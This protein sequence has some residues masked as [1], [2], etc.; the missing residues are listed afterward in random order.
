MTT[1]AP[2]EP[3]ASTPPPLGPRGTLRWM[4]RQLTSMRTALLLL[5]AL[6]IAAVPGSLIPQ[7]PVDPLA[8]G[9]FKQR[10]PT[11]SEWY[12]RF[13]MFEVFSSPWF[14]AIYLL[15][16]ISLVGCL[17]PR[18]RVYLQGMRAK[19]PAAPR[20]LARLPE[21]ARFVVDAPPA[22]VLDAAHAS[23]R[24]RRFRLRRAE[25]SVCA[26]R[27]YLR[28]TGNLL[29]HLSLIA[30]LIGVGYGHLYGFRGT[31]LVVEG[32]GFANTVT[33]YDNLRTGARFD[34]DALP[35]YS[36]TLADFNARYETEGPARGAP[37]DF[38]ATV[39]YVSKPGEKPVRKQIRV[40]HPLGVADA[41]L[42][43]G[44]H[45]YAPVV[46]V[47]DGTGAV[48]FAGA[49]P[50]LPIDPAGLS[51]RGVVKVPDAKPTQLGFQGFFLPSAAFDA[52]RG[53]F[54]T[55]PAPLNP[56]LVLNAWSGDLGLDAGLPQSVYRLNT[57][58]MAQFRTGTGADERPL[59]KSLAI[60]D[61]MELPNNLGS[62]T[63]DGYSEWVVLQIVDT[64]GRVL[65]LAGG[66]A[67][68]LGLLGSLFV[69][70]RRLW[71]RAVADSDGR[72][73]VDVG[74][75]ARSD[76]AD[77]TTDVERVTEA[78]REAVGQPAGTV[79]RSKRD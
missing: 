64:P 30:V 75:L 76:G 36:F 38:A 11:L 10:Y 2:P 12:D 63:F 51:S 28:D 67:A 35:P 5:F 78:I 49:V 61:S 39:D 77:L 19:P 56:R 9:L 72:T 40:N 48:V 41:K 15:L 46:T 31:A 55:F 13:G 53:P 8:V 69:R 34:L 33:Q 7:Q 14:S 47:K 79:D 58:K 50:F 60:G 1:I 57:D 37:R 29:F 59:T 74:A 3:A 42:F 65:A 62:L 44:P 17:V 4:W 20:H 24:A 16:M 45:G 25:D 6:A 22:A 43:L 27:G 18:S 52:A 32:G 70:P 68:I 66:I 26:E 54:S 73:V 71:V 21:H 23:L